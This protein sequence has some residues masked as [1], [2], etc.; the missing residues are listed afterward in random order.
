MGKIVLLFMFL[1]IRSLARATKL[2]R[3]FSQASDYYQRISFDNFI[4][5]YFAR[6]RDE[7]FSFKCFSPLFG[8]SIDIS[9]PADLTLR[10]FYD[11]FKKD[12][13]KINSVN[14]LSLDL[15]E[16]AQSSTLDSIGSTSFYLVLNNSQVIRIFHEKTDGAYTFKLPKSIRES[17]S[18][19]YQEKYL[20]QQF[21]TRLIRNINEDPRLKGVRDLNRKTL[22]TK[23][24]EATIDP[25]VRAGA[26]ATEA[27]ETML[28]L[29]QEL[30]QMEETK[31]NLEAK[32]L[33][34]AKMRKLIGLFGIAGQFA[35]VAVGTYH[36]YSWDIIEPTVYF[37][38][39]AVTFGLSFTFFRTLKAF[40]NKEFLNY[41]QQREFEK[42]AKQTN[43]STEKYEELKRTVAL[44]E[45]YLDYE[46]CKYL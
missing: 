35:F 38:N 18:V 41:M 23:L 22:T 20:F 13:Q 17:E 12:F 9:L 28:K 19:S 27:V 24:L 11:Q 36:I 40:D 26:D 4:P 34:R 25:S 39:L 44:L 1:R 6:Q 29:E 15:V 31:N 10:E 30:Q 33:T 7:T 21:M 45:H 37:I 2:S 3:T 5:A 14:A 32:A 16:L 8:Q 42:L 46:S 43:F